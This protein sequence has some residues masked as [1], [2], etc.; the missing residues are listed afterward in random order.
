VFLHENHVHFEGFKNKSVE[1]FLRDLNKK[2][3]EKEGTEILFS[4]YLEKHLH[5][6]VGVAQVYIA[7]EAK[8]KIKDTMIALKDHFRFSPDIYIAMDRV[9]HRTP[10]RGKSSDSVFLI[11]QFEERIKQV[12]SVL[13]VMS[14][15]N[16]IGFFRRSAVLY[17][18]YCAVKKENNCK[19]DIAL[20]LHEKKKLVKAVKN[21][22]VGEIHEA[23]EW[24]SFEK[25]K[26]SFRSMCALIKEATRPHD[27]A[28]LTVVNAVR[29]CLTAKTNFKEKG[30][31][32]IRFCLC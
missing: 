11:D 15:W 2:L 26:S 8:N 31:L 23:L 13:V 32:Y 21:G 20:S 14:P 27:I 25:S 24:I 4:K 30:I 16:N 18:I 3:A 10:Y 29:D 1:D 5:N 19:F 28:N 9:T 17:E 6:A 7:C 22:G 12:G